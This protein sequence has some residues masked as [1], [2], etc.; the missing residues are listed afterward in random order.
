VLAVLVPS[1][2]FVGL[3]QYL[4]I[5][6]SAAIF[7][8]LF[9]LAIGRENPLKAAGVAVLVPLA[10]FFMFERWFLVPLPKCSVAFCEQIEDTLTTPLTYQRWFGHR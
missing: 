4:G 9:M 6:L 5:Y 7:I 8:F 1:L 3:I 10:L 2:V